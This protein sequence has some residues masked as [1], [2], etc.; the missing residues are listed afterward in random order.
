MDIYEESQWR[1]TFQLVGKWG[2]ELRGVRGGET[3]PSFTPSPVYCTGEHS[4]GQTGSGQALEA[5]GDTTAQGK[6]LAGEARS[7][8]RTPAVLGWAITC[9]HGSKPLQPC[10][11]MWSRCRRWKGRKARE[12]HSL[13]LGATVSLCCVFMGNCQYRLLSWKQDTGLAGLTARTL[14]LLVS[15]L[16]RAPKNVCVWVLHMP[17]ST[18]KSGISGTHCQAGL[19]LP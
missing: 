14:H 17:L 11:Q 1:L 10:E 3:P 16:H 9:S 12:L 15:G 4:P 19:H 5:P 18:S 6:P 8:T 7:E 2:A 13:G